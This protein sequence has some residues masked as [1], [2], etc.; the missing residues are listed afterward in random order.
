[1]GKIATWVGK[2]ILYVGGSALGWKAGE[3]IWP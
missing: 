2:G 1:M 3:S